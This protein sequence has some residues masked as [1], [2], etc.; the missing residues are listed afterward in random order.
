[1]LQFTGCRFD[2]LFY[3]YTDNRALPLLGFPIRKSPVNNGSLP[4]TEAYRSLARPS[5]PTDAKA[6]TVRP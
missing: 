1:M 6:F 4:L 5:S 2:A 3:S